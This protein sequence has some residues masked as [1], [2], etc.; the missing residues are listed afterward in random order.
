LVLHPSLVLYSDHSDFLAMHLPMKQFLVRSWQQTGEIPLWCPHSFSGMPFVHDVQVAAF[1]PL[2]FFLYVLPEQWIGPAMSWLIV[3]HVMI[4]G[5]CMHAYARNEELGRPASLV[6]AVG[7]MFAGK[8]LL[9]ILAGGHYILIPLAWLPLVMLLLEQAI[10]R[11]SLLRATWAGVAF[12]LIVLGTHPQMTLYAGLFIC[13]WSLS[14]STSFI[15]HPSSFVKWLSLGAWTAVVAIVL[16]AVQLLPAME[17][18]PLSSRA[19]GVGPKDILGVCVPSLVGLVGPGWKESW[20]DRGGL[21]VLWLAAAAM[22]PLLCRG[23]VRLQAAL[24]LLLLFFALGGAALFHWLPGFH[25]FQLP[26]RMLMLLALPVAL[27]AG[28]T[29]QVLI[30]CSWSLRDV[31]C[32]CRDVLLRVLFVATLLGSCGAVLNYLAWR[33][34]PSADGASFPSLHSTS[35]VDWIHQLDSHA[36]TYW[37]V[38]ALTAPAMVWLLSPQCSLSR[39]GWQSLWLGLLLADAWA[40]AGSRVGV[41]SEAELYNPSACVRQLA[42]RKKDDSEQ[43]WR[44]LDRGLPGFPS[45]SPLGSALPLL[46]GLELEPVL[47]YNSFDVRRYKEYLQFILDEDRPLRPR[48][49]PFGFPV[50]STF[51]IKNKVLLDLLG[52]RYLLQPRGESLDSHPDDQGAGK[53]WREVGPVDSHAAAYSFL[54]GGVRELPPYLTFENTEAFPRAFLV[55]AAQALA[56]RPEVLE[57]LKNTNFRRE[58]LLEGLIPEPVPVSNSSGTDFH[59]ASIARYEPNRVVTR[60]NATTPGYVVLTDLWFPGWHC[61]VDGNPA[62]VYRANFLFRAV[63]VPAGRHDVVFEFA[64]ASYRWGKSL[65]IAGLAGITLLSLLLL[66]SHVATKRGKIPIIRMVA[67]NTHSLTSSDPR[68]SVPNS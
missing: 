52:T 12:A 9:H 25:L 13:L 11:G 18:A 47:G 63:E 27:F 28:Q 53:G 6:A 40:F 62:T 36:L 14:F 8:W 1:Y 66:G 42:E 59:A 4:A 46:G 34:L 17:A 55:H 30:D 51:P 3:L 37:C 50:V 35:L 33:Q 61:R 26:V 45:S 21:A 54:A 16:S 32:R 29:T 19:V 64:P 22:A 39:R 58:V 15:L 43:P 10:V 38:L 24:C 67:T 31:R 2:H 41:R 56:S 68:S 65:S 60:V 20:E 48:Q 23:R 44:V 7:Y 57:Q 5:W 49:G